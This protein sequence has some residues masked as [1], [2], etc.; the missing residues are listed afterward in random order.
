MLA[1]AGCSPHDWITPED[2]ADALRCRSCERVLYFSDMEIYHPPSILGGIFKRRRDDFLAF[3]QAMVDGLE[4]AAETA[5][6]AEVVDVD[7]VWMPGY[8]AGADER[9]AQPPRWRRW[10]GRAAIVFYVGTAAVIGFIVGAGAAG[11]A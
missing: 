10:A 8:Q 3:Q 9:P 11:V 7:A 2:G 4:A 1:T 6:A 5:P